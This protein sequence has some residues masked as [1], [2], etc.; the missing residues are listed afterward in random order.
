M[1]KYGL[2]FV[3]A[4]LGWQSSVFSW[5]RYDTTSDRDCRTEQKN[6]KPLCEEESPSNF[7]FGGD[8]THVDLHPK[9]SSYF[10]GS[11]GGAQGIYEYKAKNNIYGAA[12]LAWKQG[13]TDGSKG[14]RF[15]LYIDT[16][17][18]LGY[19]FGSQ[20]KERILTLFSGL[21]FRYLGHKFTPRKGDSLRMNY[22][23][24]YVPVG[25]ITY[26]T[27]SS[28]FT[29][30]AGF[31]WMPQIFPTVT[32]VPLKGSHWSLTNRLNNYYGELIFDFALNRRKTVHLIFYPF[33]ERW[34]DGHTTAKTKS[35]IKLGI[36]GNTYTFWGIDMNLAFYF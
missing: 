10:S 24:F 15:L 8:Y 17:E 3:L 25:F 23:E 22:S 34:Q 19:S 6:P 1:N 26:G 21:G 36:P 16:Q 13:S 7:E 28:R 33:Y 29:L 2:A 5:L 27:L 31:T 14:H 20:V 32:I 12:K 18:R 35:G 9:G 30:G 11:L 4:V